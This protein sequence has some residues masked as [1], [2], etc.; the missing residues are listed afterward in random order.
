M[1]A[2]E[3]RDVLLNYIKSELNGKK[4]QLK[5]RVGDDEIT[6]KW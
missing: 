5:I 4:C 6:T 2:I 3:I 1:I